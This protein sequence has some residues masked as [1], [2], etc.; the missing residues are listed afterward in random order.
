MDTIIA[1]YKFVK[2]DDLASLRTSLQ[3]LTSKLHIRGTILIAHEGIN[4]TL[5][6]SSKNIATFRKKI[7]SDPRFSDLVFKTSYFEDVSFRRMLVKIKKEIV[8]MKSKDIDPTTGTGKYL[9]PNEFKK[10]KDERKE[11]IIVDTRNDYEVNL[12]TFKGAIDPDI[13]SF[14]EFPHWVDKNLADKKEKTIVTFCTGGIRCEKAT[15]YMK[16]QGFHDVYQI[17]GGILNY[18]KETKNSEETSHWQ[19]DCVVFDKRKAVK[20][21]L[22]ITNKEICYICLSNLSKENKSNHTYPAGSICLSCDESLI[23]NQQ[24]R[25]ELGKLKQMANQKARIPYHR[26]N[27]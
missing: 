12:G 19:G 5:A 13:K 10:W 6:G 1:F 7:T 22:S 11:M 2:I 9:P 8:T 27:D 23:E 25:Q 24:K 4:S 3:N 26:S 15:A 16:K 14:S 21:D 20:P 18:F 17:E